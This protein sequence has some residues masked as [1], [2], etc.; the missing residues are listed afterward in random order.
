MVL[1][2]AHTIHFLDPKRE[3]GV[4]V[5]RHNEGVER[6]RGGVVIMNVFHTYVCMRMHISV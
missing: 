5:E 1:V 3:D 4:T 6:S 2:M